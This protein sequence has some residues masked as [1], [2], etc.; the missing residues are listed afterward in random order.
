MASVQFEANNPRNHFI[1]HRAF[2]GELTR[3][4][5]IKDDFNFRIVP[6]GDG[7]VSLRSV[8]FPK[9]L[10]R[11][12]DFRI[13]LEEP[14][15]SGDR[16]FALDSTFFREP[17]LADPDNPRAVSFRSVNF[18]DRYLRHRDFSLFLEPRDSPNLA[19]DATFLQE[20]TPVIFDEGS[21]GVPAD[22]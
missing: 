15:G 22:S 6:R 12:R 5:K 2:L 17:G 14:A 7:R 20:N 9:R 13:R 3:M 8:N 19:A 1:R 21:E 11:H 4:D 18:P 16:L 10:L